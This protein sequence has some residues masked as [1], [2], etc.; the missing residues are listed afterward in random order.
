[1]SDKR[2]KRG[3]L[4]DLRI[5]DL[6]GLALCAALTLAGFFAGFQ[7]ILQR[8]ARQ[9]SRQ[10]QLTAKEQR[11]ASL[12]RTVRKLRQQLTRTER[13]VANN[14]LKLAPLAALNRRLSRITALAQDCGLEIERVRPDSAVPGDHYHTVPIQLVGRGAYGASATFLHRLH[15]KLPDMAVASLAVNGQPGQPDAD[16]PA[17]FN[18]DLLWHAAPPADE[19]NSAS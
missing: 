18:F 3:S 5:V 19:P 17:T 14:A 10:Q 1:M 11:A 6:A 16:A 12:E 15:D 7:P 2:V 4:S 9:Q 8:H 13:A